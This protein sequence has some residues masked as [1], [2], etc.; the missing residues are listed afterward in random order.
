[1]RH[2][3]HK[4][5][6]TVIRRVRSIG[7]LC[8]ICLSGSLS[9]ASEDI[10]PG[11]DF[12]DQAPGQ[13]PA[14]WTTFTEGTLPALTV[15]SPGSGG[16]TRCV[17]SRRSDHGG[18]VASSRSF[19]RP[20]NRV[21]IEFSFAF[22]GGPGRSLNVWSHEPDGRDASQ[23][24]ICIQNGRLMQFDGRTR[25]WET[26]SNRVRPTRDP[27]QP[28]WHRLRAVVDAKQ[29]GIDFWL[30]EPGSLQLPDEP[31]ATRH[32]YRANLPLG[33]IDLV[34][35]QR[36]AKSAWFLIDDLVVQAGDD[37]PPPGKVEPLVEPYVL[38]TGPPIPGPG[39]VPV[40]KGVTHQTIHRA[41]KDGYKFLHGAAIIWHKGTLF[42]NW[43]NSPTN[44][45]GPHETL[46]GKRSTDG[47]Q[48]WSDLEVIGPGFDSDERHSHGVYLSR[49]GRLWVFGSRFG[50][51]TPGRHFPGLVAEV[52]VLNENT[53]RWEPRGLAMDNCWPCDEPVR[54][55]NGN[56]ITGGQDKDGLPVVAVSHGDKLTQWDTVSIPFPPQLK[57][58]FAEVT[59]L[60]DGNEVLAIIRGGGGIAWVSTSQDGG[61]T[62]SKAAPSNYPM[63]RAKAYMG[64][65][66]TKQRYILSNLGNRN[67][68]VISVSKPGEK[69]VSRIWTI[70]HGPSG[71][72]RFTG[73]AKGKQWS[74]PYG[75]EH[76]GK[77]YVVYSI[78]K[79]DCGL[80]IIP[81]ASLANE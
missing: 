15:V 8:T 37:L 3:Q 1:M 31:T 72:P 36:I 28:V 50:I 77:L 52:F 23:F 32:A 53:D 16:S 57:P 4:E 58:S 51:G 41:T 11:G 81:I 25:T 6:A 22:S 75:H 19:T 73:H 71:P 13:P 39:Q 17:Q 78:G 54:M 9:V 30:S 42:A 55:E 27:K 7:I 29:P 47:G 20:W 18:L 48:T 60:A 67:T 70:R 74:Y 59:V 61:R 56:W 63:P 43:A 40:V 26:I 76:D 12:E 5:V 34:S 35:G 24:N 80:S 21:S 69:T 10:L 49:N 14:G 79:E 2:S 38:W 68:L 64:L 33:G 66:S 44:E 45:N 46:Q 65:L 62:W